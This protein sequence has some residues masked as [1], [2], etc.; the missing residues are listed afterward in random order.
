M[1]SKAVES[2]SQSEQ[3]ADA[4][5]TDIA[6]GGDSSIQELMVAMTEASLSMEL[7]VQMRNKAVE[8]YQEIMRMQV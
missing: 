6:T 2:V 4:I 8:A 7:L 5:A 3:T 1:I